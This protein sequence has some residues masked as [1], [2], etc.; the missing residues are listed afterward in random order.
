[1]EL[2]GSLDI[3]K[4]LIMLPSPEFDVIAAPLHSILVQSTSLVLRLA[5]AKTLYHILSIFS[6]QKTALAKVTIMKLVSLFWKH[7]SKH[8]DKSERDRFKD[9]VENEKSILVRE[10]GRKMFQVEKQNMRVS[11][12]RSIREDLKY[13]ILDDVEL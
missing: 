8:L 1:M 9:A 4:R 10:M 5:T 7:T 11:S 12:I 13:L 6:S 2:I 3:L